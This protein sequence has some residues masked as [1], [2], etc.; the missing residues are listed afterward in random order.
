[1]SD[2]AYCTMFGFAGVP[3]KALH[4]THKFLGDLDDDQAA[5]AAWIIR[6]WFDTNGAYRPA[7]EFNEPAMFGPQA[8]TRVLRA[9]DPGDL[10][11]FAPLRERLDPLRQDNYGSYEPHVTTQVHREVTLP[12]DRYVLSYDYEPIYTTWLRRPPFPQPQQMLA[13]LRG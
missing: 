8:Q 11:Q 7:V 6:R 5:E 1:M 3:L 4:C 13:R 2:P 12:I 9:A 10:Q